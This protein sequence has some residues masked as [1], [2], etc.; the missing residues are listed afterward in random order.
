LQTLLRIIQIVENLDKG[1][2]EN[3]LVNIFL[4]SRKTRPDWHWT[5]YCILGK[6]GR[7]DEKVREA[8]GEII[9]SPVNISNKISFLRHLRSVLKNGSYDIIHAHHDYLSGF[10]LLASAGIRFKKRVLHIHNTDKALPVGNRLLHQMLL[11]PFRRLCFYFSDL[12]VGI[13]QDALFEFTERK[14]LKRPKFEVLYCGIDLS[15][16]EENANPA[17]F[18]SNIGIPK[19]S[20]ILLFVGRMN[21]LKNPVY[22]LDIL[23]A[24]LKSRNDVYAVF[25]G[26]GYQEA[27]ITKKAAELG[28][29]DHIRL[30]GWNDNI[31]GI[32]KNADVLVFPRKEFPKEGLG[33]V[34]VEAQAAGLPMFITKGIV[35]EAIILKELAFYTD[36]NDP[37]KWS[38]KISDVLNNGAP[39]S[40]KEALTKMKQSN[41][42]LSIAT[43][44][45]VN[46]YEN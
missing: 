18:R 22:I 44:N 31:A 23:T 21:E 37:L 40:R 1:A 38:A 35:P 46:L 34:V 13:S 45:F 36:L 15:R 5:F 8:G 26:K 4:S 24:L 17:E 19:H 32:M 43:E 16:F 6:E 29:S 33:L 10:Y 42:E 41:F 30:L 14:K 39:V 3:W 12:I 9:Y 27:I 25:V 11:G 28:L 7:L 2:V 20:K